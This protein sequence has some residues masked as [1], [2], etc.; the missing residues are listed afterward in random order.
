MVCTFQPDL[1]LCALLMIPFFNNSSNY[2]APR[3][4]LPF[5]FTAEKIP[6]LKH[7]EMEFYL[8]TR[9]FE[10][11]NYLGEHLDGNFSN[12][13]KILFGLWEIWIEERIL[14]PLCLHPGTFFYQSMFY[15][16]MHQAL[17]CFCFNCDSL[18]TTGLQVQLWHFILCFGDLKK[19]SA[20][21]GKRNVRVQ[22][23][24]KLSD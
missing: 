1:P 19:E 22:P 21:K 15:S 5:E 16:S 18:Y 23:K 9:I 8:I 10:V 12:S 14:F 7:L 24:K 2:K 3:H 11:G 20:R 4:L 17:N 6:C 13:L